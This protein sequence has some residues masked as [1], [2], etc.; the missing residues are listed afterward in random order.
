MRVGKQLVLPQEK[1]FRKTVLK[2]S[3]Q[4]KRFKKSVVS[5]HLE[6]QRFT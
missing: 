2:K 4:E 1:R 5:E 6:L 3:L